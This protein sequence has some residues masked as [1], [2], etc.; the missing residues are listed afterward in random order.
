MGTTP[1]I[2]ACPRS[3]TPPNHPCAPAAMG[4]SCQGT[5]RY[6]QENGLGPEVFNAFGTV[7]ILNDLLDGWNADVHTQERQELITMLQVWARV[8]MCVY[9]C[10]CMCARARACNIN[11]ALLSLSHHTHTH[12]HTH[13]H[14]HSNTHTRT[15]THTHTGRG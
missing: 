3:T 8:I 14:S 12:T 9:V 5:V 10:V 15:H 6:M 1:C 11:L 2:Q 13:T 7:D 4:D